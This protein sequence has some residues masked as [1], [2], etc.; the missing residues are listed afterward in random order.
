MLQYPTN[1]NLDGQTF[2]PS[3]V[4]DNNK[5]S[6]TF[7][8]DFLTGVLYKVYNYNTGELIKVNNVVYPSPSMYQDHRVLKYNGEEFETT[9]GFFSQLESGNDYAIQMQLVQFTSNGAS[10]LYDMFV[11]RGLTQE[12]YVSNDGYITIEDDIANIYEWD[13]FSI[14]GARRPSEAWS[15]LAGSMIIVIGDEQ[16][17]IDAY[18]VINGRVWITT[19]FTA[20]IPAG[21]PYQIYANYKVTPLYFFRCR[22]K[23][24][25]EFSLDIGGQGAMRYLSATGTYSQTQS[26]LINYYTIALYKNDGYNGVFSGDWEKIDETEKI[27]SQRIAFDFYDDWA[28]RERAVP[29]TEMEEIGYK[30][31]ITIRTIDGMTVEQESENIIVNYGDNST[32]PTSTIEFVVADN[33]RPNTYFP[34]NY[35]RA[36]LPKQSI[37]IYYHPSSTLPSGVYMECYRENVRTNETEIIESLH[38]FTVPN[39]GKFKY[40]V[41]PRKIETDSPHNYNKM[42]TYLKG[43]AVG[44]IETDFEGYTITELILKSDVHQWGT[45][46]RYKIGDQWKFIGEIQDTTIT[47]NTDRYLH[48]GYATYPSL[49]LTKTNYMTGTLTA[50]LGYVECTTKKYD[51]NIDLV[52]GWRDFITRPTIYMLKSPKGDVWIVN[53]TDTPTTTYSEMQREIPVTFSFSWAECCSVSDI[54]I[55]YDPSA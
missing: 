29:I 9:E 28:M 26:S 20:S 50:M 16:R 38:D 30:A 25:V 17:V 35:Q 18:T 19:A 43:I 23:P 33:D 15:A 2:D 37:D 52:R 21:T 10:P 53:I 22:T 42:T 39:R 49:T 13:T 36:Y 44:E 54:K 3:V 55:S 7:N 11:L 31:K 4:D 47:Q 45:R 6:F 51:D 1:V 24:T 8:G 12:N 14:D 40:Y 46:P 41:I 5:L 32:F 34:T 27:Y 48:V